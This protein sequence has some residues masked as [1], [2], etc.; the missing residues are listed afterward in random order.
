[1]ELIPTASV[2]AEFALLRP[3][4]YTTLTAAKERSPLLLTGFNARREPSTTFI[5][6]PI[7]RNVEAIAKRL[8]SGDLDSY[9]VVEINP[10][11][12]TPLT[13]V[14]NEEP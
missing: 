13:T 1:M 6:P 14:T 5:G 8:E 7:L 9:R 2:N 3:R 10:G 4:R 11:W 12:T